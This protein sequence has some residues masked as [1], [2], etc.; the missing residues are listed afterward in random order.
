M[1]LMLA[2]LLPA[3]ASSVEPAGSVADSNAGR[4]ALESAMTAETGIGARVRRKEDVR[5]IV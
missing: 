3:F 5:F 4:A 1:L 2:L